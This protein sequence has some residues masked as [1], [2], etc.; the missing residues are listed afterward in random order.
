MQR[1]TL[2]L[3]G[4]LFGLSGGAALIY[5]V[6]W[7]RIL[8]LTSGAGIYSVAMIVGAFMAGLGLGSHVGGAA[9]ARLSPRG[10]LRTFALLELGVAA[11]ASASRTSASE[12][13]RRTSA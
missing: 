8:A 12:V 4:L 6:T 11:F 5:Q 3:L 7:Q 13:S 1:R 10:A 9:S 2:A